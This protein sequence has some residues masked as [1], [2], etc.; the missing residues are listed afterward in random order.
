[1]DFVKDVEI[2]TLPTFTIFPTGIVAMNFFS[3]WLPYVKRVIDEF[4]GSMKLGPLMSYGHPNIT[5]S[6]AVFRL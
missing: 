4:T 5:F 1:M 2:M 6:P 3:N